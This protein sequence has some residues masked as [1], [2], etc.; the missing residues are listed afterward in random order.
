MRTKLLIFLIIVFFSCGRKN[1]TKAVN[2]DSV[3]VIDLIS[4][5]ESK[6]FLIS[7]MAT[8]LEYIPLQT[9][10]ISLVKSVTKIVT[11]NNKIYLRN[12]YTDVL[13]FDRAGK[14][15]YRLNKPGRGPGEYNF[16][17]DFDIS[18]DDKTLIVI[19][20]GNLLVYNNTGT[21][22]AYD[23][24]INIRQQALSNRYVSKISFV[25]LTTNIFLS[26]DPNTGT[27]KSLSILINTDG[28]TLNFKPNQYR[29]ENITTHVMMINESLHFNY[30]NNVCF[31][32]EFSD[33][34]FFIN[35][36]SNLF[37]PGII[38]D[39]KGIGYPPRVRYDS[40]YGKRYSVKCYWVYLINETP[41]YIIFEYEHNRTRF[42]ML[43]DKS[44]GKKIKL[45]EWQFMS[46]ITLKKSLS[47]DINGGP[48]FDP[49]FCS[50]NIVYTS[51]D[52]LALKAYVAG[53]EFKMSK[54]KD[55][56]KKNELKKLADSLNET[57]NPVLIVVT[58]KK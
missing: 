14:F 50:E 49:E 19:S 47:D 10:K 45:K 40:E 55:P 31:K 33:T 36:E 46:G 11:C 41:R 7:D 17:T 21:G 56:K 52:A 37:R 13:C 16:I 22:F 12:G 4:E 44:S 18:S 5:P 20:D 1:S 35:K 54:V 39:S 58:P 27:E 34:V 9:T 15:L 51:I 25:P 6:I 29:F 48:A 43:Y 28:D 24:S 53:D 42:T 38:F 32:E 2:A 3:I 23:K 8:D 57:D 30:E 26:I